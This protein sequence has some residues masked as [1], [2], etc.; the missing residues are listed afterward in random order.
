MSSTQRRWVLGRAGLRDQVGRLND[1]FERI[2]EIVREGAEFAGDFSGD[3][4]VEVLSSRSCR[5]LA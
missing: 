2:A 5:Q 4:V 3:F 1:G